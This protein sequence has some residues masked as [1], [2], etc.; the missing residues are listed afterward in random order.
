MMAT[1]AE[2]TG[3]ELPVKTDGLSI[4]P[5]LVGEDAAGHPQS[6]HEFMYWEYL[7]QV[8]VRKGTWKAIKPNPKSDWQLYDLKNDIS[9]SNDVAAQHQELVAEMAEFARKTRI[10]ARPGKFIRTDLQKRDR[11]ARDGVPEQ[12]APEK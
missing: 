3:S 7:K 2:L 12:L 4:L 1:L 8:A 6:Q 10:P 5:T 9:E 11:I